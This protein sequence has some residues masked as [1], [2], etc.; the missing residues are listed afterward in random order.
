MVRKRLK[1]WDL[2]YW[3][4]IHFTLVF[5][6]FVSVSIDL[7]FNIDGTAHCPS[8][9]MWSFKRST[10]ISTTRCQNTIAT[11]ASR[12]LLMTKWVCGN[13]TWREK[14]TFGSIAYTMRKRPSSLEFGTLMTSPMKWIWATSAK[15][16]HHQKN[17]QERYFVAKTSRLWDRKTKQ[18]KRFAYLRLRTWLTWLLR[19]LRQS[20]TRMNTSRR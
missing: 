1:Y 14:I 8:S 12:I 20:D 19:L 9:T 16:H 2:Q 5:G 6:N 3:S 10:I 18:N 4:L 13:R 11:T 17:S 7:N 15:E